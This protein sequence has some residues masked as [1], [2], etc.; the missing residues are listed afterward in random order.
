MSR[1]RLRDSTH[2]AEAGPPS[3]ACAP[4]TLTRPEPVTAG[5]T[6]RSDL[7]GR[8]GFLLIVSGTQQRPAAMVCDHG[9]LPD[10]GRSGT[11]GVTQEQEDGE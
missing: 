11:A 1:A 9:C 10:R 5:R 7:R 6:G 8:A 3:P 4:Q 2:G